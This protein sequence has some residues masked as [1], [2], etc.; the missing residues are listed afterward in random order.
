RPGF[1]EIFANGTERPNTFAEAVNIL[2]KPDGAFSCTRASRAVSSTKRKKAS[3]VSRSRLVM[4]TTSKAA[5]FRT[6]MQKCWAR[7]KW[8][9]ASFAK[10]AAPMPSYI[11]SRNGDYDFPSE[12]TAGRG[13][14]R[15]YGAG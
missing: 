15:L 2:Q 9:F 6:P 8:H 4:A 3:C 11:A 10:R 1:D 5:S 13:M 14:A 7:W 12:L